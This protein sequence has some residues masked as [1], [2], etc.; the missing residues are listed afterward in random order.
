MEITDEQIRAAGVSVRVGR[1]LLATAGKENQPQQAAAL[2]STPRAIAQYR[3]KLRQAG[4]LDDA[5]YGYIPLKRAAQRLG[6]TRPTAYSY[7]ERF[8]LP[9]ETL[10]DGRRLVNAAAFGVWRAT[11]TPTKR[12]RPRGKA[13]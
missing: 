8:G 7:V 9:L 1:Y 11:F 13:R 10:P 4:L 6:V 3:N 12:G 5:P 2:G